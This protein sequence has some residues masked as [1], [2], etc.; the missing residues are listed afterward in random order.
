[1]S[2][3]QTDDAPTP[4]DGAASEAVRFFWATRNAQ[5]TSQRE[6]GRIDQGAR[7]AVTGGAQMRGFI[8]TLARCAAESGIPQDCI[9]TSKHIDLP[10]YF[11]PTKQW[12]LLIIR[13][14]ELLAAIEAKSQTGPSFGNNFNNRVEEAIGS[15]HDLWVAYREGALNPSSQSPWLGYLMHLE[16]CPSSHQPVSTKEPHFKVF[17]EFHGASYCKRYEILCD[18][19][20]RE[21][22]YTNAAL[23]LSSSTEGP[24]GRYSEPSRQHGFDRLLHT[25]STHLK[26]SS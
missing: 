23:I 26:A 6:R 14:G 3:S 1:M 18:R 19:L 9:F 15:A 11:R 17:P 13:N 16:D 8:E 10:G 20:V 22:L 12:D 7:G 5:T 25:F 21:R 24:T 2:A 4:T